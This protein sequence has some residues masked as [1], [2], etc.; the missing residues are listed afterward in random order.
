MGSRSAH[1]GRL[2][3]KRAGGGADFQR[4]LDRRI[5]AAPDRKIERE[6][7]RLH[8]YPGESGLAQ[9]AVPARFGGERERTGVFRSELR[10]LRGVFVDRLKRRHE[11]RVIARIPPAREGQPARWPQ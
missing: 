4:G 2:L 6:I 10:Q 5:E 3:R 9:Y 7:A 1:V 8:V 11:K